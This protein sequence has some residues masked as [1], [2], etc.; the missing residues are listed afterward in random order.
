MVG[1][2][3]DLMPARRTQ[4]WGARWSRVDSDGEAMVVESMIQSPSDNKR[5]FFT[6]WDGKQH[7]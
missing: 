5:L 2:N 3:T 4:D 7:W 6:G 1:G